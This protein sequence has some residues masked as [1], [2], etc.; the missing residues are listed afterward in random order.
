M[1]DLGAARPKIAVIDCQAGNI[2]SVEKALTQSGAEAVVSSV[3]SVIE[4]CDGVCFL[5]KEHVIALCSI[6]EL[7]PW[8]G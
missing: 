1:N 8:M 2:R 5:V 3:P 4:S 7:T 6:C